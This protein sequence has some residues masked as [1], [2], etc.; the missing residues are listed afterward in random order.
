MLP[1]HL[2]RKL[3]ASSILFYLFVIFSIIAFVNPKWGTSYVETQ[4]H[5]GLDVVF[6]IDVSRS[7]DVR[8]VDG[9][10]QTGNMRTSR[11][12]RG[13]SITKQAVVSVPGCRVA[14]A[15]GRGRGYLSVPLTYGNEAALNFFESLDGS[16]MTGRSTNLQ[17]LI[18][19][20]LEA[21]QESSPARKVIV[22]ISDGESHFGVIRNALNQCIREGVI[23]VAV[24]IGSDVGDFVPGTEVSGMRMSGMEIKQDDPPPISGRDTQTMRMAAERTGGVYID[25]NRE[26]A[27]SILTTQLVS[28]MK[29]QNVNTVEN[30]LTVESNRQTEPRQRRNLFV[31]LAII[32][33]VVSKFVLRTR[34]S[35]HLL[36]KGVDKL[37]VSAASIFIFILL[38][39]SCTEG[40]LLLMEANFL[41]SRGKY[42]EAGV[43]YY[44]ALGHEDASPYAEYGLGITYHFMDENTVA[45]SRYANS[46]EKLIGL[47]GSEHNELRYR[48]QY[49]S[50]IIYFE[51]GNFDAAAAAFREALKIV[52]SKVEAKRNLEISLMSIARETSQERQPEPGHEETKEMLF[53]MIQQQEQQ[54]WQ[55]GE[56]AEE[57]FTGNDW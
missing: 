5:R 27:A 33:Y 23:I 3:I 4:Y 30:M 1:P 19:S 40:K 16:S 11:L 50:G 22:L 31:I 24:A 15:I 10:R 36:R 41:F 42:D 44:K 26:D 6:A 17:A 52:P 9:E 38:F 47:S 21:F 34:K 25:G 51:E 46:H 28:I 18:E 56:W 32:S 2:K 45:L 39:A 53:Q 14:T 37:L 7:M 43:A 12:E 54:F 57:R 20:A 35:E 13:L 29:G 55:S 8:D 49:N 48:L